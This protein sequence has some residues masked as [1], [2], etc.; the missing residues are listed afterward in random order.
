MAGS[1]AGL[2]RQF[3]WLWTGTL[4]N[5]AGAFV[6]PFLA[7]YLTRSLGYST[8]FAGLVLGAVGLGSIVSSLVAGVL[9]DRLGRRPVLLWSQVATA[10]TL[11]ALGLS[12]ARPWVLV[13]SAVFGFVGNAPRPA[14]AAMMADIVRPAD[15]ARAFSLNYW[16]IN[17]GFGVAAVLGGLLASSGYLLLF[18]VDAA[19]T[20]VFAVLV[21]LKV[22]ESHPDLAAGATR[23]ERG[24][25]RA[26]GSML[27]VLRDRVFM[28]FML[29]TLGFAVV[30]MQHLSTLPVQ[31]VD[32][33][34]RPAQYGVVISL[35]AFLIVAVTVPLTR[36]LQRYP[37]AHVLALSGLFVGAGFWATA[38]ADSLGAYAFTVVV[39]TVGELVGAAIAPAVVADLS[40]ASMRGRYQG[41]LNFTFSV[42]S[43]IAPVGGGWVYDAFGGDVLWTLCGLVSLAAAAGHLLA[44]P[45]R[46]RRLAELASSDA[47]TVPR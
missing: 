33:G 35:N 32:D 14:Y 29:L 11:V 3:W 5:R 25:P 40:P 45:T 16:A 21:Y 28:G 20:L 4:V 19:T 24:R 27:D 31:M 6:L 41:A 18:L 17:L 15:R 9:A 12:T 30:F 39:W 2:P 42:G 8:A 46:A 10:A 44:G 36:Y 38:W 43:L 1:L 22:P 34:L 7:I 23:L 37:T 13:L 26:A 47:A